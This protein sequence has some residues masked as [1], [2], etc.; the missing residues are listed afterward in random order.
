MAMKASFSPS[1]IASKVVDGPGSRAI[2]PTRTGT[3]SQS[4][5]IQ[6]TLVFLAACL[7]EAILILGFVA[8]ALG[9]GYE[10]QPSASPD[11]LP[12]GEMPAPAPPPILR[13][14]D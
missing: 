14:S 9:L 1:S 8:A 7:I 11:R 10:R 5:A 3:R 12:S 4:G 6:R 2:D 13:P